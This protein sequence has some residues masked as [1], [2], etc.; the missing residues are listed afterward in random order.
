MT[1]RT[2]SSGGHHMVQWIASAMRPYQGYVRS[3]R[4]SRSFFDP[5]TGCQQGAGRATL[6]LR[7]LISLEMSFP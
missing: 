2:A 5:T 4:P 7:H 3:R 1:S 6:R